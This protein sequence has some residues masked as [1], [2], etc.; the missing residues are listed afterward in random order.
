V[1]SIAEHYGDLLDALVVDAIDGATAAGL[2]VRTSI[3]NT[4]MHTEKDKLALAQ[5]CLALCERLARRS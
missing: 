1:A 4:L 2:S 3:A 5:H